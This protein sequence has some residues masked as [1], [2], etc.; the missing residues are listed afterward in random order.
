[1]IKEAHKFYADLFSKPGGITACLHNFGQNPFSP[2][3]IEETGPRITLDELANLD[4]QGLLPGS[5]GDLWGIS[6]RV[7]TNRG[8][9]H[10]LF[11]ESDECE[12]KRLTE[13]MVKA[14][15][16]FHL[17]A[18]AILGSSE[19]HYH[20]VATKPFGEHRAWKNAI[21]E[22]LDAGMRELSESY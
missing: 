8:Y 9:N 4:A 14:A 20:L 19:N 16:H 5:H 13:E 6:S 2:F 10:Y 12:F 22:F 17:G 21:E 15:Q 18:V 7:E 3:D 1:M 11:L